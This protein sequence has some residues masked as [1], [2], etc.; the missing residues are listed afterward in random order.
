MNETI[1][2]VGMGATHRV[3]S[4]SY[5]YTIVE[6]VSDKKIIVQQ[7]AARRT[8]SNGLSESQEYEYTRNPD[9]PKIV[10]TKRKD[11]RWRRQGESITSTMTFSL[12]VRR[13]YQDPSF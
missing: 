4:D 5:P 9:S 7:D 3:G 11:G 6:V 13:M 1:P 10:V 8:D 12:G 2:E